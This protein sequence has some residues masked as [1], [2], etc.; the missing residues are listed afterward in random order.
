MNGFGRILLGGKSI[1]RLLKSGIIQPLMKC[2]F[3]KVFQKISFKD[4][5]LFLILFLVLLF[6]YS[7]VL[8]AR[9]F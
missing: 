5:Y 9:L 6:V 8:N 7:P 2:F 4:L 1:N 3:Q